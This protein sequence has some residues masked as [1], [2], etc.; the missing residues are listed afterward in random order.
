MGLQEGVAGRALC[1]FEINRSCSPLLVDVLL[2][3]V[4]MEDML[5]VQI[6]HV[7]ISQGFSETDS[8]ESI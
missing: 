6:D 4:H 5:A 8:A 1:K 7:L 2:Q 3:A